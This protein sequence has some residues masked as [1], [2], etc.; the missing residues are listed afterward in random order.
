MTITSELDLDKYFKAKSQAFHFF[1]TCFSSID[2][3]E[4]IKQ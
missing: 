2:D 1:Y 3:A 4:K